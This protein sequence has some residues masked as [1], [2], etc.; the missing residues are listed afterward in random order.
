M[1]LLRIFVFVIVGL[2]TEPLPGPA[3]GLLGISVGAGL[4]LVGKTPAE[5]MR[6]ALSGFNNDVVWLIFAATTFALGYEITGLGRR[7]ALLLVKGLGEEP[8]AWAMPS[9][10]RTL[11]FPP[12]CP[13]ILRAAPAPFTRY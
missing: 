3:M 4:V 9:R 10:W 6:W 5:S 2:V 8:W 12:S 11:F 13:P 7:I 1:A